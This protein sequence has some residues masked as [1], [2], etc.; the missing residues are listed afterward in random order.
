MRLAVALVA[1]AL[2]GCFGGGDG[3]DGPQ[4]PT[5]GVLH[6]VVVDAAIRPLADA[7]VTIAL[8]DGSLLSDATDL[9]GRWSFVDLEPGAYNVE[10]RLA[11]YFAQRTQANV[12]AGV[13]DPQGVRIVLEVNRTVV[14]A[15]EE[16]AFDGYLQCSVTAI[17]VRQ[18]C[19]ADEAL[20]P[21]CGE[22]PC[23][24]VSDD[25]FLAVHQLQT[26]GMAWIQ[27]E[28]NWDPSSDLAQNLR[29]VPGARDPMSGAIQDFEG[30]DGSAPLV[31]TLSGE[32]ASALGIGDGKDYA[33]RVF[34]SFNEGT[35]PPCLPA[36]L[37]CPWGVGVAYQQQFSM[38]THVFYGMTPPEGWLFSRDGLPPLP[39]S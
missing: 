10:A 17:T 6:G 37:G 21:F 16:Y 20:R 29:A 28:L 4:L 31:V 22:L 33:V 34:S 19:D 13:P 14:A 23:G 35:A 38:V 24:N 32:V 1:L 27:S 9:D 3:A 15:I 2:A 7:N 5:R 39:P 12:T 11:G 30:V 25:R 8:P 26:P 18:A 36:P